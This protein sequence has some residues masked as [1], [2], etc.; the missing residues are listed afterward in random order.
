MA[1]VA[2]SL[3]HEWVVE[4]VC[5]LRAS[6]LETQNNESYRENGLNGI[7]SVKS[8]EG[9]P[10]LVVNVFIE[11]RLQYFLGIVFATTEPPSR[12]GQAE[13]ELR[14]CLGNLFERKEQFLSNVVGEN[15]IVYCVLMNA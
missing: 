8:L 6:R 13:R 9:I 1:E 5:H 11:F 4:A 10:F 15:A 7:F 2:V 12:Q 14:S 3:S